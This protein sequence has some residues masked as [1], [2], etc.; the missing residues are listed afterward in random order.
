VDLNLSIVINET[1]ITFYTLPFLTF[2]LSYDLVVKLYMK[3]VYNAPYYNPINSFHHKDLVTA[4]EARYLRKI[5]NRQ[6]FT[7]CAIGAL[8][9]LLGGKLIGLSLKDLLI[10]DFNFS[11]SLDKSISSINSNNVDKSVLILLFNKLKN[12]LSN[13][14]LKLFIILI[15][16]IFLC[17]KFSIFKFLIL[18]ISLTVI[19]LIF[20]L[21]GIMYQILNLILL[22]K[23]GREKKNIPDILPEFIKQWLD[24]FKTL[25]GKEYTYDCYKKSIYREMG[26]YVCFIIF[27]LLII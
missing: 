20:P 19:A 15:I 16:L 9:L 6:L 23:L 2:G 13:K 1:N 4:K 21:C 26:I 14:K 5:R 17:F 12:I 10:I 24:E 22:Y 27:V 8:I 25:G 3:H 7:F 11:N 18:N